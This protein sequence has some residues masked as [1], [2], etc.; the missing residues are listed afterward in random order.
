VGTR[1]ILLAC[2]RLC[3]Q[4]TDAPPPP[5][6]TG[7][8]TPTAEHYVCEP[9]ALPT[10]TN[11]LFLLVET[12]NQGTDNGDACQFFMSLAFLRISLEKFGEIGLSA[13]L[14]AFGRTP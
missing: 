4:T 1:C 12:R 13:Q 5:P 6:T 8:L 7:T 2:E 9:A 3:T 11:C 10:A 14:Q